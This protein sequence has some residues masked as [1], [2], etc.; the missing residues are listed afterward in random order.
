MLSNYFANEY[1]FEFPFEQFVEERERFIKE[2][3]CKIKENRDGFVIKIKKGEKYIPLSEKEEEI[4]NNSLFGEKLYPRELIYKINKINLPEFKVIPQYNG[5]KFH[6]KIICEPLLEGEKRS[7]IMLDS[8]RSFV[9][10]LEKKYPF[11][12]IH[13]ALLL[14]LGLYF[15]RVC[16][17]RTEHLV[18]N[19]I[20]GWKNSTYKRIFLNSSLEEDEEGNQRMYMFKLE[21]ETYDSL[22]EESV[23]NILQMLKKS[24]ELTFIFA[25]G[26]LAVTLNA[27]KEYPE[28]NKEIQ[29]LWKGT[30]TFREV[31]PF[32]LCICGTNRYGILK[33][34][35]AVIFLDYAKKMSDSFQRSYNQI[36]HLPLKRINNNIHRI[37]LYKDCPII[38]YPSSNAATI[39]SSAAVLNKIK[40]LI[41]QGII[42]GFPVLISEKRVMDDYIINIDISD[43]TPF[44][45]GKR[46]KLK[47][48]PDGKSKLSDE[49]L[50]VQVESI[51]YHYINYI[52]DL[53][54]C[55]SKT[56]PEKLEAKRHFYRVPFDN[57]SEIFSDERYNLPLAKMYRDL[58]TALNGFSYYIKR[59]YPNFRDIMDE[60][61]KQAI[62]VAKEDALDCEIKEMQK[63]SG[64]S[65]VKRINKKDIAEE[66]FNIVLKILEDENAYQAQD[67]EFLLLDYKMFQRYYRGA[68]H[69]TFLSNCKKIGI[70]ETPIRKKTGEPRGYAFD[71]MKDGKK[72]KVL[73]IKKAAFEKY[74]KETNNKN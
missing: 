19:V 59:K 52:E 32:Q 5:I 6:Y 18:K 26:L 21:E 31:V 25:Y 57:Y 12:Q 37:C 10:Q 54:F 72:Y 34:D 8:K 29:S 56:P 4:R 44:T 28:R 46:K 65:S 67:D 15:E 9:D 50:S 45:D 64:K 47:T 24:V 13:N 11:P 63:V 16:E 23:G 39:S 36:P 43:I 51:V 14:I 20:T 70:I 41:A 58:L 7:Y 68:N 27:E 48:L 40:R 62:C 73:K 38:M 53:L 3:G 33:K 22:T 1:T 61:L 35:I 2:C 42:K 74:K 49:D 71:K 60:I 55:D 66:F 30:A 69:K 17:Y